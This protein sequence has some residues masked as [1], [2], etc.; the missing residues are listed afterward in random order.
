LLLTP[1]A[2]AEPSA[3]AKAAIVSVISSQIDAFRRDDGAEAFG[4]ASPNIQAKF[5]TPSGFMRMVVEGYFPVYRP[6]SV[7]FLDL[8]RQDE[9]LIQRV[10]V[11]GPDGAFYLALYPM[12]Q[13]HDGTWRVDGCYL[14][15]AAGQGI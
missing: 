3:D 5:E 9:L 4:Y 12:V 11:E 2:G 6:K 13:M 1:S 10:L 14:L 7:R 8:V 15:R